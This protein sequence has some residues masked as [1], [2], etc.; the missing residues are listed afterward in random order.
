MQ[1][2]HIRGTSLEGVP[3]EQK[4]L[5]GHLLRSMYQLEYEDKEVCLPS[6]HT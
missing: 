2:D 4:M 5:K 6:Q 1:R 3:L